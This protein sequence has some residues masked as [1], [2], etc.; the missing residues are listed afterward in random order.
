MSLVASGRD[1]EALAAVDRYGS[2]IEDSWPDALRTFIHVTRGDPQRGLDRETIRTSGLDEH[3][4]WDLEM[5][6]LEGREPSSIRA[7]L[8]GREERVSEVAALLEA[9]DVHLRRLEGEETSRLQPS[10]KRALRVL[11]E[12]TG[13]SIVPLGHL[14][15]IES[16]LGLLID[17]EATESARRTAGNRELP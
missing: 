11:R 3:W 2:L 16:R 8:A 4:Y 9:F 1:S 7:E 14:P 6:L 12:R 17:A 13:E 15:L 10:A 5:Q